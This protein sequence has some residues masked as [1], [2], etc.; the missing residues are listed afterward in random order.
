MRETK[1]T[2]K[3]QCQS[4]NSSKTK[5][6]S[7]LDLFRYKSLRKMTLILIVVDCVFYLRY[8]APT[9]MLNQFHFNIFLNGVAIESA[10]VFAAIF[11]YLTIMKIPRRVSGCVSFGII[12]LCS[13]IL[14]F[15]WDQDETEVKN[16]GS[17]IVV[18]IFLFFI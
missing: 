6:F 16:I 1:E 8:L 13:F 15:I 18:L 9:L 7:V 3:R 14:I 12:M 10:Q 11:G 4:Q 17:G 5:K 2:Y